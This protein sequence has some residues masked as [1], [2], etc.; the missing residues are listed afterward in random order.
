MR[1]RS[2]RAVPLDPHTH[3]QAEV[4]GRRTQP[5]QGGKRAPPPHRLTAARSPSGARAHRQGGRGR[6]RCIARIE[7]QSRALF[8]SLIPLSHWF[9]WKEG[10]RKRGEELVAVASRA[11]AP[12]PT[13]HSTRPVA[14]EIR[15]RRSET[16]RKKQKGGRERRRGRGAVEPLPSPAAGQGRPGRIPVLSQ[17]RAARRETRGKE[18]GEQIRFRPERRGGQVLF[19]RKAR[20]TVRSKPT[21]P[22]ETLA[23]PWAT[24]PQERKAGGSSARASAGPRP[25]PRAARRPGRGPAPSAAARACCFWAEA[26]AA[27]GVQARPRALLQLIFVFSENRKNSKKKSLC[28]L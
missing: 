20:L 14:G 21:L 10:G 11:G 27:S 25:Q 1:R 8:A 12:S 13:G 17:R 22:I 15:R 26:T 4:R 24:G 7:E 18:S 28:I 23:P 9:R 2:G 3:R 6:R 19:G 16:R 5:L